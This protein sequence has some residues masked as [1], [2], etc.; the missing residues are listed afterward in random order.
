MEKKDQ[1]PEKQY[2]KDKKHRMKSQLNLAVMP[3]KQKKFTL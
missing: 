1:Y 3:L 2:Q